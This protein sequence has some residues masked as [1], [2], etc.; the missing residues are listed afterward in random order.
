MYISEGAVQRKYP[1]KRKKSKGGKGPDCQIVPKY[2]NDQ[3][4]ASDLMIYG[5]DIGEIKVIFDI[6][7]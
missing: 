1:K 3:R 4:M 6:H 7:L 5:S 2:T